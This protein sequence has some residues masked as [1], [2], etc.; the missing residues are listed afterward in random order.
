MHGVARAFGLLLTAAAAVT[1]C[2]PEPL[3]L[4]PE[5]VGVWTT[6]EPRYA[7]R[8]F[9]LRP[10]WVIFGTG[11]NTLTMHELARVEPGTASSREAREW[12]PYRIVYRAEN[13]DEQ[14]VDVL[15]RTRGGR[16]LRFAHR[17]EIWTPVAG[18]REG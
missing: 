5:I 10:D 4:P 7:E 13:G 9:E 14:T 15:F 1:G 6:T 12:T 17:D 2:A 16:A 11:R 8:S 18:G 3:P